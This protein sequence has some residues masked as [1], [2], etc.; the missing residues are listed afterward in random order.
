MDNAHVEN[1]DEQKRRWVVEQLIFTEYYAIDVL[2]T[3]ESKLLRKTKKLND[4]VC[5]GI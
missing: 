5:L 1:S 4:W 2:Q 3:Q